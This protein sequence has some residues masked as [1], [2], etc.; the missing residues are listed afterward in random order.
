M[1]IQQSFSQTTQPA[2]LSCSQR[3][4]YT[5]KCGI[6]AMLA[7]WRSS[8]SFQWSLKCPESFVHLLIALIPGWMPQPWRFRAESL[9]SV[10]RFRSGFGSR[11][12]LVWNCA[13]VWGQFGS[14]ELCTMADALLLSLQQSWYQIHSVWFW[15]QRGKKE[16]R[17]ASY[18]LFL[19]T[20]FWIETKRKMI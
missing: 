1:D 15:V 10:V 11:R 3:S 2:N 12:Q 8:L 6:A 4:P 5:F 14:F 18:P 16:K 20:I 13:R 17:D 9:R 7:A 19:D